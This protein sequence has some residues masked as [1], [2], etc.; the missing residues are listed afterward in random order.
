MEFSQIP[1]KRKSTAVAEKILD[2]IRGGEYKTGDKLPSEREIS[3]QMGVGRSSIREAVSALR[4]LGIVETKAGEGSYVTTTNENLNLTSELSEIFEKC[5]SPYEILL[6]RKTI[7]P[8]VAEL[9]IER[10]NS[11]GIEKLET[12]LEKMEEAV[13][14]KDHTKYLEQHKKFHVA[15]AKATRNYGIEAVITTL[16]DLMEQDLWQGV[17]YDYLAPNTEKGITKDLKFHTKIFEAIQ[18]GDKRLCKQWFEKHFD[19]L[20]P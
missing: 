20:F 11:E 12:V 15:I 5:E 2:K 6:A 8:S 16:L 4:I 17:A 1:S 19:H 9:A 3:L 13:S 10:A 7:E 14:K 18:T